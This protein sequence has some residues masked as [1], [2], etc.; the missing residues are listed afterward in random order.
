MN[1]SA[2]LI[3]AVLLNAIYFLEIIR[4]DLFIFLIVHHEFCYAVLLT[5][6]NYTDSV[7]GKAGPNAGRQDK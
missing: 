5:Y 3:G 7:A 2:H 4:E 6:I 1:M